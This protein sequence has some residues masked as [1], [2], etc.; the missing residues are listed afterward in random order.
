MY[1]KRI[2]NKY[3]L[4]FLFKQHIDQE[5]YRKLTHFVWV[6]K[7]KSN[8]PGT[9]T[10]YIMHNNGIAIATNS[11]C[12]NEWCHEH[13]LPRIRP[14]TQKSVDAKIRLNG[15]DKIDNR[16]EKW[17]S[18]LTPKRRFGVGSKVGKS[19]ITGSI[20]DIREKVWDMYVNQEMAAYEIA[21]VVGCT[22]PNVYYHLRKKQEE[23][24]TR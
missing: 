12:I 9:W 19:V 21:R 13:D 20:D 23:L 14:L 8:I 4:R 15:T 5:S 22:P 10:M 1:R 6:K 2:N 24:E 3:E 18:I 17:S 11:V 7:I 16:T